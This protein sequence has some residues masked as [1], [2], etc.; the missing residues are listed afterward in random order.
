MDRWKIYNALDLLKITTESY[1]KTNEKWVLQ[2]RSDEKAL[3]PLRCIDEGWARHIL[4]TPPPYSAVQD[5]HVPAAEKSLSSYER[6]LRAAQDLHDRLEQL[7]KKRGTP[8]DTASASTKV[9]GPPN[10]HS[11]K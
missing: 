5:N 8:V 9:A 4:A 11:S 10:S 7:D 3:L 6:Q 1:V 2:M